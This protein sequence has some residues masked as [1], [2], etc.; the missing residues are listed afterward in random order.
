MLGATSS[1]V[2]GICLEQCC[3]FEQTTLLLAVRTECA[4]AAHLH[5]LLQVVPSTNPCFSSGLSVHVCLSYWRLSSTLILAA[6]HRAKTT[7]MALLAGSDVT[8]LSAGDKGETNWQSTPSSL[9]RH[10]LIEA[11]LVQGVLLL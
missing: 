1:F 7:L 8:L 5:R 3:V 10:E 11:S 9:C 6:I 4:C 2:A